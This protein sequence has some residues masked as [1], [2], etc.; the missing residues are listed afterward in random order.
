MN[1]LPS[2]RVLALTSTLA[3]VGAGCSDDPAPAPT[4]SGSL[5]DAA[6]DLGADVPRADVPRA[7]V[8]AAD[9][10]ATDVPAAD[11]PAA[12]VPATD[13]PATDVPATDVPA[14]DVPATDVPATDVPA[15]D[16]PATDVPATDGGDALAA[17]CTSTGGTIDTAT[18]CLS[19]SDFPNRC[20]LGGCSCGPGSTH[21][22]RVCNCPSGMCF[23]PASG[24][25][26]M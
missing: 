18:C 22:I 24:C 10:P 21:T 16:V 14:A 4:D 5:V 12:D 6:T 11:V 7:D 2:V 25:G 9:V 15:T 8:P 1:L 26:A 20:A 17:L 19:A 23:T 13:V 3:L